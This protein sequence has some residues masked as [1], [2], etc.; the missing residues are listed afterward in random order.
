M[1]VRNDRK[2]FPNRLEYQLKIANLNDKQFHYTFIYI[3]TPFDI[4]ETSSIKT[5]STLTI[6]TTVTIDTFSIVMTK[7]LSSETFIYVDAACKF[8]M[9]FKARLAYAFIRTLRISALND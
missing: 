4:I 9:I 5:C 3:N 7:M 6:K 1:I 2:M 8:A